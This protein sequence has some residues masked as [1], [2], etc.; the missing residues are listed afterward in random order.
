[1]RLFGALIVCAL[2]LCLCAPMCVQGQSYHFK[3]YTS[4]TGL[5]NNQVFCVFQ[6]HLGYLWFGTNSGACRYDGQRFETFAS[7]QGLVNPI[8]RA[9]FEDAKGF[10]WIATRGGVSRFDGKQFISY[11]Q[12]EGLLDNEVRS[13]IG[14]RDGAVWFGSAKGLSR[15]DGVSFKHYGTEAGLPNSP[16]WTLHEDRRGRL[17]IGTRGGGLALF[18]GAKFTFFTEAQGFPHNAVFDITEDTAGVLW[19]ATG[20]GV[21]R[22][23][24]TSF[25][26]YNTAHG[27][28]TN[29]VSGVLADRQ[30]RIWCTTFGG[31][32]ARLEDERFLVFNRS[33]GLPDNYLTAIFED[34]EG[35]IWCGTMWNGVCRFKSEMFTSYTAANGIGEGIIT[36]IAEDRDHTL[37]FSSVNNGL[38]TLSGTGQTKHY[39]TKDGLLEEQIWTLFIDSRNRVWAGGQRGVS[40]FENGKFSTFTTEQ[41]GARER[42]TAI[43]EDKQG[44]LWFGTDSP[45]SNGI[46]CYNGKTFT[47]YSTEQ[48]L[49]DNQVPFFL[50]DNKDTLWVCTEHGLSRF[51][52]SR[53]TNF[54][55][56]ASA[57]DTR[58]RCA[59]QDEQGTLW[60]G[61]TAGLCRFDGEKLVLVKNDSNLS[62]N[63]I[64]AITS[65]NGQLWIGTTQ[66]LIVSDGAHFRTYTVRDGLISNDISNGVV[67]RRQDGSIWFGTTEGVVCCHP[68]KENRQP[69]APRVTVSGVHVQGRNLDHSI[70]VDT[71]S[72]SE[73]PLLQYDQNTITFEF[74][75][76]SFVDEESV[77]Y[78]VLLEGFDRSW[79]APSGERF[80]RYTNL[81]P[82][83][84]RFQVKALSSTGI[85]SEPQVVEL[86]IRPPFWQTWPFRLLAL[87]ALG[88]SIVGGYRWQL[89]LVESRHR[90]RIANLRRLLESVRVIN[91][92]LDLM[93]V[94]QN[95]AEQSARLVQGEPGGIGLV[96]EREVVF[97]RVWHKDH[98]ED[99]PIRF[100]LGQ[101]VAGKVAEQATSMIVNDARTS[102]DVAFPEL[103]PVYEVWG[104]LD[105]PIVTRTGTVVGV[106]DV[107]R[108]IGAAPFSE[109]DCALLEALANQAAVAIE[110]AALYG[111]VEDK[112]QVISQSL[113]ELERLYA[114]EQEVTKTLQELDQMKTNFMI[115]TSHEMR[116]PLTVIKGYTE[117]LIEEFLGPLTEPQ[118]RSL[119]ACRRMVNRMATNF[120][121]ILEMLKINQGS[122]QLHPGECNLREIMQAIA[123]DFQEFIRQRN[124]SVTIESSEAGI[125]I[126]DREKIAL[127]FVNLI[128]NAIKFTYD[129]GTI[130]ISI[131]RE[132]AA[133]HIA[134][135][136]SGI[137]IEAPEIERIFEKFYTT[138]DPSTHKSGRF[139]FA[140][141][142]NGLG[143]SI[144]KSYVEAHQGKI[145]AESAGMGQGSTF[146]VVLP[147]PKNRTED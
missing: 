36:G 80:A 20:A 85:W 137:G 15:F 47:R 52:G 102:P 53:F 96:K 79:S 7:Q 61:T 30:G 26:V 25:Q 24:G 101:G 120:D 40:C 139:E 19:L 13:G 145:W 46:F 73:R 9:I 141:R 35:S 38:A 89:R 126:A 17:W 51:D 86:S 78:S 2:A 3:S 133:T 8:V 59:Y 142:G 135:K 106:L 1:M 117:T 84:Y 123:D 92:Q 138:P 109:T 66:G 11:T 90:R 31:G 113:E 144:A 111:E 75:G 18:D 93:T 49:G 98:W 16:V 28:E 122:F 14:T 87:L 56:E 108:K 6:D 107:R 124:Q 112:N 27:L 114:H 104:L 131:K 88:G 100:A 67:W 130:H 39:G 105:V 127:V 64:R 103:I 68:E 63:I 72:T 121:E 41:M 62:N 94:L 115:V 42:I 43:A 22:S 118:K 33:N 70:S 125:L 58:L 134:I 60:V 12:A 143:L 23:D 5:P 34:Y 54:R 81:P 55:R 82:N 48:G 99:C 29:Q 37:W 128:Q 50:V 116:T 69:V 146:H 4:S 95:I 119:D 45:T 65:L 32:L 57:P 21:C 74:A 140:T 129:G 147:N 97:S 91:S 132:S 110:N 76:L 77:R 83:R 71:S 10:L 44:R 136:D